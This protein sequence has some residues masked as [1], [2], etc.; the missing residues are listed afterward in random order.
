MVLVASLVG[1][2]V[3]I[4]TF[5]GAFLEQYSVV[6]DAGSTG[7]R[8]FV[9]HRSFDTQSN[10][11]SIVS[12]KGLKVTPGLSSFSESMHNING[13]LI[14]VLE[15]AM[16]HV[17]HEFRANTTIN[18]LGTAGMRLLTNDMQE[19]IW[20]IVRHSILEHLSFIQSDNVE[21]RTLDGLEEAYYG[22]L[23]ANYVM[24]RIDAQLN[25]LM[26][27]L[28]GSLDMGGSSTQLVFHPG[29]SHEKANITSFWIHSWLQYGL[30]IVREAV[31]TNTEVTLD[32]RISCTN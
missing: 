5:V 16:I 25:P 8:A 23:S 20:Y 27:S 15:D 30:T 24:D 6:I 32:W 29:D 11:I 4:C 13:Y 21:I 28:I 31:W 14:P 18:M 12:T 22:A 9:F 19:N 7:S 3:C 26:S 2:F 10:A 17:P 1:L